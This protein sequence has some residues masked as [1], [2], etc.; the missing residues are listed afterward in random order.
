MLHSRNY[1]PDQTLIPALPKASTYFD[2]LRETEKPFDLT[3]SVIPMLKLTD[4]WLATCKYLQDAIK[5]RS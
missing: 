2:K 3:R 4:T 5:R 1:I